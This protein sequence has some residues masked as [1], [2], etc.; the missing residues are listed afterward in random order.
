M[1]LEAARDLPHGLERH[2]AQGVKSR[3]AA[4]KRGRQTSLRAHACFDGTQEGIGFHGEAR[5]LRPERLRAEIAGLIEGGQESEADARGAGG[6]RGPPAKA[7]WAAY[8]AP[9]LRRCR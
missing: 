8:A 9:S 2:G 1:D 7:T 3:T 5:L 4:Q 6:A